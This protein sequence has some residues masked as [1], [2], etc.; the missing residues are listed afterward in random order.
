MIGPGTN[1]HEGFAVGWK[2]LTCACSALILRS[3]RGPRLEG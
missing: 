1:M 2:L 3:G